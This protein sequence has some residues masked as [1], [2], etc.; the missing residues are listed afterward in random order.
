MKRFTFFIVLLCSLFCNAIAED[1]QP[2]QNTPSKLSGAVIIKKGTIQR[3]PS[4]V[5][6][7]LIIEEEEVTIRFFDDFGQGFY[8]FSDLST[9]YSISDSFD[10]SL[11]NS[12]SLPYHVTDTSSIELT[13]EFQNGC[14]CHLTTEL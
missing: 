1:N 5:D 12:I 13:I 14:W 3:A 10:C 6:V 8:S 11:D 4:N 9:G 7:L 2:S